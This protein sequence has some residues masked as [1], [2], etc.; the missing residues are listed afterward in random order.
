MEDVAP[1]IASPGVCA[2]GERELKETCRSSSNPIR[3]LGSILP[4]AQAGFVFGQNLQVD[5]GSYVG[6]T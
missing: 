2:E 5:G 1:A 6:L 4:A 3:G